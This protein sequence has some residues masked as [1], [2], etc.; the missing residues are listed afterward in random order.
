MP[1]KY[2]TPDNFLDVPHEGGTDFDPKEDRTRQEF[3]KECDANFLLRKYGGGVPLASVQ[4]GEQDF[5]V[6]RLTAIN[7][8][9]RLEDAFSDLPAHVRDRFGSWDAV[10]AAIQSGDLTTLEAAQ[11][12]I[13]ASGGTPDTPKAG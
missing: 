8:A 6:D 5:D 9:R 13:V 7:V 3:K 11:E 12:A 4:Y 2:R 1:I 10:F